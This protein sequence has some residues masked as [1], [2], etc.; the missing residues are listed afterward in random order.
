MWNW[1]QARWERVFRFM[2]YIL[3]YFA[4]NNLSSFTIKISLSWLTMKAFVIHS[5]L[6]LCDPMTSP[7]VS[8]IQGI[9]QA[10]ILEWLPIPFSR[11]SSQSRDWTRIS[12]TAGR[13]FTIW[14]TREAFGYIIRDYLISSLVKTIAT[15]SFM[16]C[17]KWLTFL[18]TLC[19]SLNPRVTVTCFI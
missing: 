12:C 15:I 19:K 16:Y 18:M 13:F 8:S 3:I 17:Y 4:Q 5:R 6:T 9:L 7:P 11:R 14:A 2:Y 1:I 10:R